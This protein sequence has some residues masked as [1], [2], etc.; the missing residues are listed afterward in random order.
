M[1]ARTGRTTEASAVF[2]EGRDFSGM[3]MV[4]PMTI[5]ENDV[6]MVV[7]VGNAEWLNVVVYTQSG[8]VLITDHLS[9]GP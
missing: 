5:H 3:E 9:F 4:E 7:R 8:E 6:S 1:T 2:V